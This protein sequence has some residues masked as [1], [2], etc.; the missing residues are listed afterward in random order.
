MSIAP[1]NWP[2]LAKQQHQACPCALSPDG[3]GIA[4]RLGT[5]RVDFL[6]RFTGSKQLLLQLTVVCGLVSM[7]GE[8]IGDILQSSV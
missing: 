2:H 7:T 4:A 5:T 6:F 3:V 8:M 1:G